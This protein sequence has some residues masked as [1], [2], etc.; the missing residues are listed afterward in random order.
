MSEQIK[1]LASE[2]NLEYSI[3]ED[4]IMLFTDN[5]EKRQFK[6]IVNL[7]DKSVFLDLRIM[8]NLNDESV[9]KLKE[10]IKLSSKIKELI[11]NQNI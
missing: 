9:D 2:N 7:E 10:F 8:I 5:D 11:T 1:K 3:V 6:I 4:N